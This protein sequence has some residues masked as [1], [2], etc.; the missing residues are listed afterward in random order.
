M[1]L[2]LWSPRITYTFPEYIDINSVPKPDKIAEG[3]CYIL[4]EEFG[5][6]AEDYQWEEVINTKV[7]SHGS[8]TSIV[9]LNTGEVKLFALDVEEKEVGFNLIPKEVE[10]SNA[11]VF[12]WNTF[13]ELDDVKF[14]FF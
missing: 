2:T 1:A 8:L 13:G 6:F 3:I 14:E 10:V 4:R 11:L 9:C 12:R 5:M 7:S